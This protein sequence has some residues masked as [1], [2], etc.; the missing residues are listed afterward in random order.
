MGWTDLRRNMRGEPIS[1]CK[2]TEIPPRT[3]PALFGSRGR[4]LAS[5]RNVLSIITNPV[6]AGDVLGV[7]SGPGERN[8]VFCIL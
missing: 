1:N 5:S 7:L 3:Q 8:T 6:F 4:R 2:P